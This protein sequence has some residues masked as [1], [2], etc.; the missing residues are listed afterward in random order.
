MQRSNK[1]LPNNNTLYISRSGGGKSQAVMQNDAIPDRGVRALFYDPNEDHPWTI[2]YNSMSS[3]KSA[4]LSACR[5][6]YSSGRGFRLAY[7]GEQTPDT[8]EEW[9]GFVCS[10]L[11]GLYMTYC[12]DEEIASSCESVAR[13]APWHRKLMNQ[14]RKYGARYH[15]TTQRPQEIPKTVFEQC[16]IWYV[17][18]VSKALGKRVADEMNIDYV[19]L[20]NQDPLSFYI[21]NN[22]RFGF[23]AHH[24]QHKY[25]DPDKVKRSERI[26]KL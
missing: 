1:A 26:H 7:I 4:A 6:W 17:G 24:T 13:A 25:K 12:I 11:D 18:G 16:D 10:V 14:G 21:K 3:F 22:K 2:K 5:R 9:C 20:M 19:A 8:H 15:G 23:T